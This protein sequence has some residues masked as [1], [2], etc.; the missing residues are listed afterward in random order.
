M[1]AEAPFGAPIFPFT[2]VTVGEIDKLVIEIAVRPSLDAIEGSTTP[3][4]EM[5][6]AS[7]EDYPTFNF[8]IPQLSELACE[9][10]I[11]SLKTALEES[12][13]QCAQNR[14]LHDLSGQ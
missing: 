13:K 7:R 4:V 14:A 1:T 10:L 9:E 6:I 5:E 11:E 3:A 2:V 12:R 8:V